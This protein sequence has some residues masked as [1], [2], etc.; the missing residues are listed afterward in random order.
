MMPTL[1]IL[2]LQ[3]A[4]IL[5]LSRVARWLFVPLGQPAVIGEM[6]AGL[7]LGPSFFGWL[8]PRSS[9]AL[10]APP[11]LPSLNALSQIGLV[12]FMF[13]V[14]LRL[15]SPHLDARRR[16]AIVTSGTSI[17]VPFVLGALLAVAVHD[18]LAPAGVG[19]LPFALFIGTAMS[20]TAFPVLARILTDHRLVTTEIGVIAIACAAFD[21]VTGWL[22]LGG[23]TA[24]VRAGD[25]H[26]F[27]TRTLLF[28]GYL[29]IMMV[30]VRPALRWFARW[31]GPRFGASADDLAVGLLVMLLSAVTTE[32]L[33][34]HAL[35]GAFFAGLMMPRD[36]HI[37]QVFVE[38][39][40]PVTM[41]L[42]LPLFFAFTGLRTTVQ[43]IDSAALWR[44]AALILTVAV[45][46]KGGGSVLAARVMGLRW[47]DASAL[48]V[49]LNTRG[50]IELVVLNIGLELG[51]L[52]PVVF[53]MMVVMALIT[54]FM[55]SPIITWL[56]PMDQTAAIP[57][58]ARV[59]YTR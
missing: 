37:E 20:I 27:V 28:V 14:G 21:D 17:V 50:L 57:A 5:A 2:L 39:V 26:A 43:L 23:V 19:V 51:I 9:A 15:G 44:D 22:I 12:L 45:V 48:G 29:A 4:V 46:G 38:R 47:R 18:R 8:M 6:V 55:T 7:M 16:V 33:G 35:F 24:L 41:T 54:T 36:A 13:L 40:E 59:A 3:V 32:S 53:S 52:S 42:L 49:L 30:V 56:L 11:T 1:M 34:V 58:R 25:A 31:R 10:F